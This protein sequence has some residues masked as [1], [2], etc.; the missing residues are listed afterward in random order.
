MKNIVKID[1]RFQKSV[2]LALDM[3][4]ME[5]VNQYIPTRSSVTI[6]K[7]YLETIRS[8]QGGHAT[9][10]IGPYGKGKSHLL[11][12]LMALLGKRDRKETAKIRKRILQI[13]QSL[14]PLLGE[15]AEKQKPF[16]GVIISSFQGDLNQS[17][18]YALQEAL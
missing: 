16:L 3:G 8:R 13:D 5:R 1:T 14:E 18:L 7:Q 17:F 11:L 10:L 12:V 4:D 6:L 2:N 9:V 15:K